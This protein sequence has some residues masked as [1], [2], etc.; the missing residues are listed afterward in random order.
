MPWGFANSTTN[1]LRWMQQFGY[2]L[3]GVNYPGL[4]V[5]AFLDVNTSFSADPNNGDFT[6]PDPDPGL[7]RA[8]PLSLAAVFNNGPTLNQ[9]AFDVAYFWGNN[10][11][12]GNITIMGYL[13]WDPTNVGL[14]QPFWWDWLPTPFQMYGGRRLELHFTE[15]TVVPATGVFPPL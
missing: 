4:V 8:W 13:I 2:T 10:S 6:L 9:L 14:N 7:T 5:S 11:Y 15:S 3:Q 12:A 1:G